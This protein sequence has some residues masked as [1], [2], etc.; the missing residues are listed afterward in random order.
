MFH[1]LGMA[2]TA[3]L[4]GGVG[5]SLQSPKKLGLLFTPSG[6]IWQSRPADLKP[7]F[8]A[9]KKTHKQCEGLQGSR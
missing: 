4:W 5:Q 3:C 2:S 7:L 6:G 1:L 9:V 8:L